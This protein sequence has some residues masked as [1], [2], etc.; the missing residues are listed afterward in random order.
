MVKNLKNI[1]KGLMPEPVLQLLRQSGFGN[2]RFRGQFATWEEAASQC[3]GYE[4][5][6]ILERV[7]ASTL[8]VKRG[9]AAYER[10]SILFPKIQY[11]LPILSGLLRAAALNNGTLNVLD[12]GGSLG[13]SYFQNKKFLL[14]LKNVAW[15]IV[16]QPHFVEAGREHIQ[17]TT[18]KFYMT[19]D[20]CLAENSPNVIILS[21]VLQYVR[22]PV[23][24]LKRLVG[25]GVETLIIDR[26]CYL[27]KGNCSILR[28]QEVSN[29]I[30]SAKYPCHFFIE[31]QLMDIPRSNN[32]VLL[33][34]FDTPDNLC[35][36]AFWRGHLLIKDTR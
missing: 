6:S 30:Y 23:A 15:N 7:L 12:F 18:V 31:N 8:E 19:I 4:E 16:E 10:D 3:S 27:K 5:Q 14:S 33:E 9:N 22:D 36:N 17:D 24:L 21:G 11:S 25:L 26:T 34:Y 13:S 29:N 2:V 32:Y 35:N 20:D 1:A 28:V